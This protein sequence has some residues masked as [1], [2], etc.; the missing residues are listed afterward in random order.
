MSRQSI[1]AMSIY[2]DTDALKAYLFR[3][4]DNGLYA[5]SLDPS[6]NNIPRDSCFEGWQLKTEFLLGG[7]EPVPASIAPEP[8]LQGVRNVGY[9][10]WREGAMRATTR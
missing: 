2:T 6:G 4:G 8:I 10:V 3:C 9:Y 7:H 5:V 1:M